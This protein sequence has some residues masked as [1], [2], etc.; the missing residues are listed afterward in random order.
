[1]L[2]R[3]KDIDLFN[4]TNEKYQHRKTIMK[5]KKLAPH[6]YFLEATLQN[7]CIGKE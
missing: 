6:C 7:K 2:F 1:M 5:D 4:H 3:Y